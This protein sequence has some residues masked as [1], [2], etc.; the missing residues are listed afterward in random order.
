MAIL[1]RSNGRVLLGNI[2]SKSLQVRLK[3]EWL[4]GFIVGMMVASA[5]IYAILQLW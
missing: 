1:G 2:R 4:E 3:R 5:S